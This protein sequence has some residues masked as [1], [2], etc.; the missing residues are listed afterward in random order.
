[1]IY[2]FACNVLSG[3]K[4]QGPVPS[5]VTYNHVLRIAI[6]LSPDTAVNTSVMFLQQII[7]DGVVPNNSTYDLL[8]QC[9]ANHGRAGVIRPFVTLLASRNL[10]TSNELC[11]RLLQS[12]L[13]P[14]TPSMAKAGLSVTS[15]S[16]VISAAALTLPT[17]GALATE[18]LLLFDHMI[19]RN[20]MISDTCWIYAFESAF[21]TENAGRFRMLVETLRSQRTS[22][23]GSLEVSLEVLNNAVRVAQG[24]NLLDMLPKLRN[25]LAALSQNA[26][27]VHPVTSGITEGAG[28]DALAA[29]SSGGDEVDATQP[30]GTP[31]LTVPPAHASLGPGQAFEMQQDGGPF[32]ITFRLPSEPA[33]ARLRRIGNTRVTRPRAPSATRVRV[34]TVPDSAAVKKIGRRSAKG[35]SSALSQLKQG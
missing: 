12:L 3:L 14:L 17:L 11:E 7:T 29:R 35:D 6:E 10:L 27:L 32:T 2:N 18:A 25:D 4:T 26:Q 13:P 1:M 34:E 15:A 8:M 30:T 22:Q 21:R 23:A 33:T 16:D 19:R 31:T 5:I 28:I 9:F 24:L 20:L